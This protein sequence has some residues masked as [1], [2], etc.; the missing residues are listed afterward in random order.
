MAQIAPAFATRQLRNLGRQHCRL[1]WL[2]EIAMD[3]GDHWPQSR[4]ASSK[5][6]QRERWNPAAA[7]GVERLNLGNE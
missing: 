2:R 3:V 5:R 4:I 7:I 6:G 1:D